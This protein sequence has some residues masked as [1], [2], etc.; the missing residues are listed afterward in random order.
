M[1]PDRTHIPVPDP[2]HRMKSNV[3][4]LSHNL[5]F[6]SHEE[7][8]KVDFT[9]LMSYMQQPTKPRYPLFFMPSLSK[10]ASFL[11]RVN[12]HSKDEKPK[13]FL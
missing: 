3:T 11:R 10:A 8:G 2:T 12:V 13:A 6:S 5:L 4:G 7:E 9:D 1:I